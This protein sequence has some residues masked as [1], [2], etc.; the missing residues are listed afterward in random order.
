[1]LMADYG[2]R[3]AILTLGKTG[4]MTCDPSRA[5]SVLIPATGAEPDLMAMAAAP[6]LLEAAKTV[7][8]GLNARIDQAS[9]EGQPVPVFDGIAALHDAIRKA[10]SGTADGRGLGA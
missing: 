9:E 2:K 7:L 3:K 8:A 1:M 10:E 5:E 4:L 6:D